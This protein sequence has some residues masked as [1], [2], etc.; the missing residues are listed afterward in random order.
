MKLII[1]KPYLLFFLCG[2][3]S[4]FMTQ[5]S[6]GS[7]DINNY[8]T[9]YVIS[10][11]HIG[12]LASSLLIIIG[13]VYWLLLKLNRSLSKKLT[14][15]HIILSIG[16]LIVGFLSSLF[17]T[18]KNSDF[19]LFDDT[20]NQAIILT[21]VIIVL[22]IAQILFMVNITRSLFHHKKVNL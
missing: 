4:F 12:V 18:T 11:Y 6:D 19:P 14:L 17:S 20:S 7:T 13:L 8:D 15:T 2:F 10:N 16:S 3:I 1:N 22:A 5:S 9:Y 21:V